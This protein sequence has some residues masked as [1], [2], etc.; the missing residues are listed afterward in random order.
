MVAA[1]TLAGV[2]GPSAI[3]TVLV[4]RA[5]SLKGAVTNWALRYRHIHQRR[6]RTPRKLNRGA[7]PLRRTG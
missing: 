6:Q 2:Y 1:L 3:T 4:Y 5:I 7:A